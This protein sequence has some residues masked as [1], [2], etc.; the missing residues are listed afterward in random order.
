MYCFKCGTSMPD[1]AASCPQCG[2]STAARPPSAPSPAPVAAPA[3][4]RQNV[5]PPQRYGGPAQTDGKAIGSLIL[6][7]LAL[8]PLGII[9]AIPA[10]VLGHL[11]KSSIARSM[12][13]LKGEGMA[14]AGLVMGY[15]SI[16]FIPLVLI[17]AAIAIPN[18]LRARIAA[19]ESAAT[20]TVRTVNTAQVTYSTMYPDK[21]YAADLA[22]MGPGS[23]SC[24]TPGYPSAAHACLLDGI[25]AGPTCTAGSWCTKGGY[26]YSASATCGSD[27]A[28][29]DF[30]VT[31]IP[32][33]PGST[34][35]KSFCSTNDAIVR[36]HGGRGTMG[37]PF[38]PLTVEECKSWPPL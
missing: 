18:L 8:F 10:V 34:G 9:A 25:L 13:R 29:S 16:A 21:G 35:Q 27:G 12:G 5:V 23:E 36:V 15:I 1:T 19:N 26:R 31:A 14:L 28:C 2:A 38:T 32:V 3:P 37:G 22:S 11:A 33:T 20:S 7:I 4:V 6:G 30:V 17:I 24:S